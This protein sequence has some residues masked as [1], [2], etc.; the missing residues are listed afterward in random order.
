MAIIEKKVRISRVI[1][2]FFIQYS[3][4]FLS[5]YIKRIVIW[6]LLQCFQFNTFN[7]KGEM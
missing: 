2:I 3:F 5:E 7:N 1:N 4:L 6:Q